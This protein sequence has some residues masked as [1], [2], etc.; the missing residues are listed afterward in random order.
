[1]QYRDKLEALEVK[2]D[3]LTGQM[4]DNEVINDPGEYRK[5]SKA[6]SDAEEVVLKFREWK[7]VE[8]GLSTL[9]RTRDGC[10]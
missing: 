7:K 10:R 1:M 5:V 6:R 3:E 8:D 9:T 4:A 2:Y